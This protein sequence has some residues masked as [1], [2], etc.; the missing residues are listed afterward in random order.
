LP[1]LASVMMWRLVLLPL[2]AGG[3]AITN[4]ENIKTFKWTA[5]KRKVSEAFEDAF[6]GGISFW[7]TVFDEA[8]VKTPVT[9]TSVVRWVEDE[10][11][12]GP[13]PFA[14]MGG[15]PVPWD[16]PTTWRPPG[17]QLLPD[18]YIGYSRRQLCFIVAKSLIG[19]NT[20]SYNNGL[21]RFLHHSGEGGCLPRSD[22]FGRAFWALLATC[23]VDP[24]L[25]NGGQGPM[26]IVVKGAH[27]AVPEDNLKAASRAF[28]LTLAKLRVCYDGGS[29]HSTGVPGV[30]GDWCS[31]GV[32]FMS[33]RSG[34]LQAVQVMTQSMLGGKLFGVSCGLGGGQSER[35][36]FHMP[37]MTALTFFLSQSDWSDPQVRTP[38]AVLGARLI[39]SG[40]D[41]SFRSAEYSLNGKVA[42]TSDLVKVSL[43]G[44]DIQ[45]S[46]SKPVLA[47]SADTMNSLGFNTLNWQDQQT[48][49]LNR[50][51]KQREVRGHLS[52]RHHVLMWYRGVALTSYPVEVRPV[53]QA[54]VKSI[55]VGPWSA[56]FSFGD[57]ALS[58]M[59]MWIGHASAAGTWG[60]EGGA[61]FLDYFIYSAFVE[62]PSNQC[63]VHSYANCEACIERCNQAQPAANG[64]WLPES[65]YLTWDHSNPCLTG[66]KNECPLHGFETIWWNWKEKYAGLLWEMVEY[67]L[68][69]NRHE[70][71]TS[72]FDHLMNH[73]IEEQSDAMAPYFPTADVYQ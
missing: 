64:Y 49:R 4:V 23:S 14:E 2:A 22:G 8:T 9:K 43:R 46:S 30:P 41:G 68:W 18:Q 71:Q 61:P 60:P 33:E 50:L 69:K 62:N 59:A 44:H 70:P 54:L 26:L 51:G 5:P 56:G 19:S 58:F 34:P 16:V 67:M 27:G 36:A 6:G 21:M 37:E 35:L 47:F 40:L 31:P 72:V 42:L 17:D 20:K 57:S 28:N 10:L 48:A 24:T 45:V 3:L 53:L 7:N 32:D 13:D 25:E 1:H 15:V 63:L 12:G 66:K 52:F 39:L 55:G 73:M 65:A 29:M 11:L 38:V